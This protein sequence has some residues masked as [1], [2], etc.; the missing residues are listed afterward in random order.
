MLLLAVVKRGN[1]AVVLALGLHLAAI[2]KLLGLLDLLL[3]ILY[4][5]SNLCVQRF[6]I[7]IIMRIKLYSLTDTLELTCR[8]LERSRRFLQTVGLSMLLSVLNKII[9]LMH[10]LVYLAYFFVQILV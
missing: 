3:I 7:G 6:G 2:D 10:F 1:V 4:L 8:S 5:T 9:E